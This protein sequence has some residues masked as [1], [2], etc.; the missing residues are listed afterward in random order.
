VTLPEPFSWAGPHVAAALAGG[1]V[2]FSSRAGGVSSGPYASLNLGI[3]TGDERAAVDEN[4]SRLAAAAGM[5]WECVAFGRQV[6][7]GEVRRVADAGPPSQG[8]DE[9]GQATTRDDVAALVFTADCLPVALVAQGGVAML[10]GG[11]RGLDAG[12]LAEGVAALRELGVEGEIEAAL[13]PGA[14]GC[15]YEVG[16]EVHVRFAR[17]GARR[18]ERNLALDA[19]AAVQL[20]EAG[21]AAVH[22]TGLCTMC[23]ERFFSHRRDQGVTGRQGGMAW[24]A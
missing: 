3:L 6:H 14:R 11:W 8:A 22:D 16:E 20:R 21:V 17:Y 9:D 2:L 7:G 12:I 4:R 15:C 23:D 24:R 13:G 1:R 5:S 19:V 18:G 10:H